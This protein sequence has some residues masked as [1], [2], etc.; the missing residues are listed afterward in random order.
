MSRPLKTFQVSGPGGFR[1]LHSIKGGF[2]GGFEWVQGFRLSFSGVAETI[3]L[4]SLSSRG[5]PVDFWE[6]HKISGELQ[7]YQT[8]RGDTGQFPG[9]LR[10]FTAR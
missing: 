9:N 2:H 3:Q 6:P 7:G 4:V 1:W 5:V 10:S 8:C